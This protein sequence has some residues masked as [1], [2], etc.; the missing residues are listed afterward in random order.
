M[1]FLEI[2][3]FRRIDRIGIDFEP[4]S[5][6]PGRWI[7]LAGINGAGKTSI[8]QALALALLGEPLYR[9]L[10][11]G[12]LE[13]FRRVVAGIRQEVRLRPGFDGER[14]SATLRSNTGKR[15][16]QLF[17]LEMTTRR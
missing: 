16:R 12:R 1:K 4:P 11:G 5:R 14:V 9:E 3:N 15:S 8:L 17:R 7:C 13:R 6:L 2:Q 10:G